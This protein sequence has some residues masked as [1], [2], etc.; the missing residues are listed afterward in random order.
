MTMFKKFQIATQTATVSLQSVEES[1]RQEK[2]ADIKAAV[3]EGVRNVQNFNPV[4]A[5]VGTEIPN[6]T[7][8]TTVNPI[9]GQSSGDQINLVETQTYSPQRTTIT[10]LNRTQFDPTVP[11]KYDIEVN[12]HLRQILTRYWFTRNG[13][14]EFG[15]PQTRFQESGKLFDLRVADLEATETESMFPNKDAVCYLKPH[16]TKFE[17]KGRFSKTYWAAL[18]NGGGINKLTYDP[19][20][21]LNE[22]L[23]DISFTYTLPTSDTQTN[24]ITKSSEIKVNYNFY[25]KNYESLTRKNSI[26][27]QLM[28]N[29]YAM[30][31]YLRNLSVDKNI[32]SLLTLDGEAENILQKFLNQEGEV[33]I[34]DLAQYFDTWTNSIRDTGEFWRRDMTSRF[35][36]IMFS[37]DEITQGLFDEAL[38]RS[39]TYPM[40]VQI[41]LETA[42]T[43]EFSQFLQNSKMG[44]NFLISFVR[45]MIA[46]RRGFPT[47]IIEKDMALSRKLDNSDSL[48][49]LDNESVKTWDIMAW[50]ENLQFTKENVKPIQKSDVSGVNALQGALPSNNL[51][52]N[53]RENPLQ[54]DEE[55]ADELVAS[56]EQGNP[57]VPLDELDAT[58]FGILI[59]AYLDENDELDEFYTQLLRIILLGNFRTYIKNYLRTYCQMLS[60][61]KAHSEPVIYRVS[62]HEVK[63]K[64]R[65]VSPPIQNFWFLN[66][67]EIDRISFVD[68][69]VKYEKEYV[70]KIWSYHVVIGNEY[71]YEAIGD[72]PEVVGFLDDDTARLK[73]NN[74]PKLI[75]AE[76]MEKEFEPIQIVDRPPVPPEVDFIPYIGVD[77][78]I[79]ISLCTGFGERE[80]FPIILLEEDVEKIKKQQR[81][82]RADKSIPLKYRGDDPS[83]TFEIFRTITKPRNYGDFVTRKI[84]EVSTTMAGRKDANTLEVTYVAENLQPNRK[85]YYI[86]RSKDVHGNISNPTHIYELELVNN[87]GAVYPVINVVNFEYVK[88]Q[89]KTK[90]AK[91]YIKINVADQQKDM[92]LAKSEL[93]NKT[94]FDPELDEM[95]L[96]PTRE[97]VWGKKFKIR[98]TSKST[99]RK[100]DLNVT[101]DYKT[102]SFK[103]TSNVSDDIIADNPRSF[104]DIL[105]SLVEN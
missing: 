12:D 92:N 66:S 85:Y 48:N 69:Q 61:D 82:Q 9:V 46:Q 19:L 102:E 8:C 72:D 77:D 18:I 68:T 58:D 71:N 51:G 55:Q 20:V 105:N 34:R 96:G 53:R 87:D 80:E 40:S 31:S 97:P 50:W 24:A 99:G 94:T 14:I 104:Y 91:K 103:I 3:T 25:I 62:K 81:A 23:E 33:K 39:K 54:S 73:I 49:I 86:F 32:E 63:N 43:T 95:F 90:S 2:T 88:N 29:V 27:E 89:Y 30:I 64:G 17:N 47:T 98:F 93:T 38:T 28:P 83:K 57:L 36:D 21:L 76:I 7:N 56:I 78:K 5:F 79:A 4:S 100:I 70:Y 6:K 101:F 84:A 22:P 75:L 42:A 67:N 41:D 16:K 60:G 45:D 26:S 1:E 52:S 11:I 13:N 35:K 10:N 44:K 74:R 59:D 37:P 15:A 65:R